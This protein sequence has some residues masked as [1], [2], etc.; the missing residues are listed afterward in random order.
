M[1]VGAQL[2]LADRLVEFSEAAKKKTEKSLGRGAWECPPQAPG[3]VSY[4]IQWYQSSL[5]LWWLLKMSHFLHH[6]KTFN[7]WDFILNTVFFV[8][9]KDKTEWLFSK[10]LQGEIRLMATD[11]AEKHLVYVLIHNG[12]KPCLHNWIVYRKYVWKTNFQILVKT[13][14]S[15]AIFGH[16]KLRS[17]TCLKIIS[18]LFY[19]SLV[20][21]IMYLWMW[22]RVFKANNHNKN[23]YAFDLS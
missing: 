8:E 16:L 1:F 10:I 18:N 23:Y 3:L 5:H 7:Y 14:I 4:R 13:A 12:K 21:F 20:E 9:N 11:D 19:V 15:S 6:G 22:I 2:A 17:I